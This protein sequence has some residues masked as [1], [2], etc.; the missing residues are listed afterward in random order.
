MATFGNHPILPDVVE[1]LLADDVHTLFFKADCV[2]RAKRGTIGA[3]R[4]EDIE[5][6]EEQ[7]WDTLRLESLQE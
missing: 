6:Q 5:G 2:P 3:L 1:A 7:S 4:L